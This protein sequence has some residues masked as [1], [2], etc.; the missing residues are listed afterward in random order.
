MDIAAFWL[1]FFVNSKLRPLLQE[2]GAMPPCQV[3]QGVVDVERQ[4]GVVRSWDSQRHFGFIEPNVFLHRFRIQN[5][6]GREVPVGTIMLYDLGRNEAGQP[7][8]WN[9]TIVKLPPLEPSG[10]P[11]MAK[12]LADLVKSS[13][14]TMLLEELSITLAWEKVEAALGPLPVYLSRWPHLFAINGDTVVIEDNS[15]EDQSTVKSEDDSP[16]AA[17]TLSAAAQPFYPALEPLARSPS[18]APS[19]AACASAQASSPLETIQEASG[20]CRTW[21]TVNSKELQKSS[22]MIVSPALHTAL[23]TFKLIL[24]PVPTNQL[25]H[26]NSLKKAKGQCFLELK[27]N[28]V[29]EPGSVLNFSFLLGSKGNEVLWH[30]AEHDFGAA[31]LYSMGTDRAKNLLT[32]AADQPLTVC[33]ESRPQALSDPAGR[34]ARHHKGNKI[35]S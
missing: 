35:G 9:A 29:V 2:Q 31:S 7:Q 15:T 3:F 4:I 16:A 1:R 10:Q 33:L 26:G 11:D 22:R 25:K 18:M 8:A 34:S 20:L 17:S 14:G 6:V 12:T 21:W 13:G 5:L 27:C 30:S 32:V 19:P 28:E 24:R 23:G